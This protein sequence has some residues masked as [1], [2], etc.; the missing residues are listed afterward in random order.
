MEV[1]LVEANE[2]GGPLAETATEAYL[3][4]VDCAG[5]AL[6]YA[7]NSQN[8]AMQARIEAKIGNIYYKCLHKAED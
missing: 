2:S 4:A 3:R 6:T 5:T 8:T 1:L 7:E